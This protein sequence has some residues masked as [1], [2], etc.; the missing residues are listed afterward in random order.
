M[1]YCLPQIQQDT[2]DSVAL[3]KCPTA[4]KKT[5]KVHVAVQM[6]DWVS[7]CSSDPVQKG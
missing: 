5:D 3:Y 7:I 2:S 1:L 6:L 4:N